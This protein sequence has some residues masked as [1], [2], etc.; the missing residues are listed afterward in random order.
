[1]S[2]PVPL[3]R[4]FS[5]SSTFFREDEILTRRGSALPLS[6][7][8]HRWACTQAQWAIYFQSVRH[9]TPIDTAAHLLPQG[10]FAREIFLPCDLD[11]DLTVRAFLA[12]LVAMIMG[13]IP[14]AIPKVLN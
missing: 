14:T 13:A 2:Q 7:S 11:L 4:L 8:C 3:V 6:F 9:Y 10:S 12:G 5:S 1:M